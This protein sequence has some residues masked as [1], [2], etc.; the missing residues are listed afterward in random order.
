MHMRNKDSLETAL[1][2]YGLHFM[3]YLQ[4]APSQ[5]CSLCV[6][7]LYQEKSMHVL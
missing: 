4:M 2:N 3:V 5:A 6:I 1:F 7:T